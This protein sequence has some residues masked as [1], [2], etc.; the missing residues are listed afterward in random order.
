[1]S[2]ILD[3]LTMCMCVVVAPRCGYRQFQCK[4]SKIC[5]EMSRKCDFHWD[6]SDG[7]DESHCDFNLTV[8]NFKLLA[9]NATSARFN[10][11]PSSGQSAQNIRYI[12]EY[13]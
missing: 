8:T 5:I 11:S 6:C 2:D 12:V 4:S 1:M 13:M 9:K 7:S 10:W 3:Q